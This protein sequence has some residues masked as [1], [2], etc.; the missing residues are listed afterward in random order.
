[1]LR[2]IEASEARIRAAKAQREELVLQQQLGLA[3]SIQRAEAVVQDIVRRF[4]QALTGLGAELA[5]VLAGMETAEI[6]EKI[7]VAC[8]E[9]LQQFSN[10][11]AALTV[12]AGPNG[13]KRGPGRPRKAAV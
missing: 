11:T 7:D 12:G 10:A 6:H 9:I 13:V 5:P 4:V 8:R 2:E 3:I 1:V